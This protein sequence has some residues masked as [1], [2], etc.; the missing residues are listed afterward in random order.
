MKPGKLWRQLK[1]RLDLRYWFPPAI[2]NTAFLERVLSFTQWRFGDPTPRE[3]FHDHKLTGTG[4]FYQSAGLIQC[5]RCKGWQ[6]IRKP[7]T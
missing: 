6:L 5:A 7:I 3:C 1:L 2:R 4:V